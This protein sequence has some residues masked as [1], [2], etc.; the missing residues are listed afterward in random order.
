MFKDS[1]RCTAAGWSRSVSRGFGDRGAG[2]VKGRTRD[3]GG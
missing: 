3:Q 2:D 1:V